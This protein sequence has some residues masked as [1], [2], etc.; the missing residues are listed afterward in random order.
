MWIKK[1]DGDNKQAEATCLR[2]WRQAHLQDG[3]CSDTTLLQ[4]IKQGSTSKKIQLYNSFQPWSPLSA[5]Y[6][7]IKNQW[8]TAQPQQDWGWNF[9]LFQ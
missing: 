4:P 2:T 6:V 1:W 8:I 9:D 3:V 5:I 7:R